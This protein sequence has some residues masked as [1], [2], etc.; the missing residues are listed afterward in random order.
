MEVEQ[1]TQTEIVSRYAETQQC[2]KEKLNK[3]LSQHREKYKPTGFL[4]LRCEG[5]GSPYFG[6]KEIIPFGPNHKV[7]EI[8]NHPISPRGLESD[9]S[10]I[11]AWTP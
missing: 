3:L 11:E 10:T 4:L 5:V 6:L 9:M 2:S 1:I 8:P 7:K